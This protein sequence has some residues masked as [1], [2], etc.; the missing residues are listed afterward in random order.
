MA[1]IDLK[2]LNSCFLRSQF[3]GS[4]F[5]TRGM[6]NIGLAFALDPGL[7]RIYANDFNGLQKARRRHLK[8]YNTHPYWNPLLVGLFLSLESKIAQGVFP[9]HSL[10]KVKSTLVYTLS[11]IGDSFFSG[12]LLVTWSLLTVIFLA[13]GQFWASIILGLFLFLFLQLFK[14]YVFYQGYV[15][16]LVFIQGLKRWNLINWSGRLKIMN[17][18]LVLCFWLVIW[19]F[20]WHIL[21]F[22]IICSLAL[23]MAWTCLKVQ[24]G[25]EILL[26]AVFVLIFLL[27]WGQIGL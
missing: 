8:L 5:N 15:Q 16:G 19:P 25:R 6:Q 1:N 22:S 7:R 12:S 23:I 14:L 18:L 3:M 10:P 11:A 17:S 24:W 27:P 2:S 13:L 20:S 9:A 26:L 21:I 4:A